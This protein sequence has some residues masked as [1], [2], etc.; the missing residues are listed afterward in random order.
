M[1]PHFL[2]LQFFIDF[3][4]FWKGFGKVLEGFWAG[5]GMGLEAFGVGLGRFGKGLAR[6]GGGAIG[7]NEVGPA[8]RAQR[9]NIYSGS[10]RNFLQTQML[11]LELLLELLLQLLLEL[12]L[13]LLLLLLPFL[14]PPAW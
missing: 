2:D 9:L 8:D 10:K 11:M 1:F 14:L 4:A 6:V 7:Q 13:L 12:L 3:K 5:F